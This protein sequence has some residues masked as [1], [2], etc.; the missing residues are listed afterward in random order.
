MPD[1][2][3][4]LST[5]YTIAT[6]GLVNI[7]NDPT[8]PPVD[9]ASLEVNGDVDYYRI[10]LR[11]GYSYDFL[12]NGLEGSAADIQMQLLT[13]TNSSISGLGWV[14]H[15][16]RFS[17]VSATSTTFYLAVQDDYTGDSGNPQAGAEG[18]YAITIR[19]G[20]DVMNTTATTAVIAGSG[21]TIHTLGQSNDV[22][23][24][25]VNL[26]AGLTY[27]F[28]LIAAEADADMQIAIMNAQNAR[29]T[30]ASE[31]G[32]VSITPATSGQYYIRIS[33]DYTYDRAAEGQ[34]TI[35][36]RMG[37]T[38]QGNASTTAVINGTGV[39]ASD[40]AQSNDSDWFKVNLVA[41]RSY[42]FGLGGDG[43][44]NSLDDGRIEIRTKAGALVSYA[45]EN[46]VATINPTASDQYFIIVKDD[47]SY[48]NSGEG[49]YRITA[50]MND[51]IV[52]NTA[53]TA[54]LGH[55][56]SV[57][58]NIDAPKDTD[59][60]KTALSAGLTYGFKIAGNGGNGVSDPDVYLRDTNGSTILVYGDNYSDSTSTIS[61][62]ATRGG[63][64]FV[65]AG[66]INE[67]DVGSYRLTSIATDT[68]RNDVA[69]GAN[70]VD[71]EKRLGK[72]DV[73]GDA[74][75]YKVKLVEGREY[76][77]KLSGNTANPKLAASMLGLYDDDGA[78]ITYAYGSGSS[79]AVITFTATATGTYFLG[80]AGYGSASGNF[81]LTLGSNATKFVGNNAANDLTGNSRANLLQGNGGNDK[82]YG[83][84][85]NDTLQGGKGND[86]LHGGA[87]KD[88]L[89]GGDGKDVLNGNAGNDILTGGKGNDHFIFNRNGDRDVI[90]DFQDNVDTIH[91]VGLG[92]KTV[93]Q[94][95]AKAKQVGSD[96]VFDFGKGDTLRIEDVTKNQ[97]K[98]D[99]AFDMVIG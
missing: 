38:I 81:A 84:G 7:L 68:V 14:N 6:T 22:D 40:L 79:A 31:G 64:Y 82:L 42:G 19:G 59:W 70:I 75:W 95:L 78:R 51:T 13:S 2:P 76:T 47:Y 16:S 62:T 60:F 77:I 91:L 85:G 97:L 46:G 34:Y 11:A 92:V 37:D 15:G 32:T 98:N 8:K 21:N 80:A 83:Q 56:A 69:T 67:S 86:W 4:N 66:N 30:Y 65:Q 17:F 25:K 39:I 33:D 93:S 27:D 53:T 36:A 61:Y 73:A 24:F 90:T 99:L 18:A 41:G 55:N 94:A 12:V 71:G 44:L 49:N 20:D 96:V 9:Y 48:D 63:T 57:V 26:K 29:L 3:G 87:G 43:S 5:T 88:K 50:M 89:L 52:N 1:V 54:T 58:S 23:Y 74:D 28:T 72:I 10:T 45:E 35:T